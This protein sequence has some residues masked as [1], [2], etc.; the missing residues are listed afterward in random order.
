MRSGQISFQLSLPELTIVFSFTL[1][2]KLRRN[3]YFDA[4]KLKFF[5]TSA[6]EVPSIS[7]HLIIGLFQLGRFTILTSFG[8]D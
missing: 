8:R 3:H 7:S 5:Q 6:N 1:A 4:C 2:L